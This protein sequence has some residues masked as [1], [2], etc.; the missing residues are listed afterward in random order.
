MDR[1]CLFNQW[2]FSHGFLCYNG[3]A[4][5][6]IDLG[7]LPNTDYSFPS[8]INNGGVIVGLCRIGK[9]GAV[10]FVYANGVM[11][12]INDLLVKNTAGWSG[13]TCSGINDLG[14]IAATGSATINGV[15]V[16]HA[17]LLNPVQ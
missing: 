1:W 11:R 3:A 7:V 9:Y 6:L 5:K 4:G 13:I 8:G 15:Q 12:N 14:Q 16:S 10:G 17:L 2:F